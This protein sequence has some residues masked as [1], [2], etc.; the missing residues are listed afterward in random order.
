MFGVLR[1]P[2]IAACNDEI[3]YRNAAAS[4]TVALS[5]LPLPSIVPAFVTDNAEGSFLAELDIVDTRYMVSGTVLEDGVTVFVFRDDTNAEAAQASSVIASSTLAIRDPL[6]IL[7]HASE[8]VLPQLEKTGDPKTIEYVAMMHRGIFGI[9]RALNRLDAF[10]YLQGEQPQLDRARQSH[11]DLVRVCR[12]IAQTV[13]QV[14]DLDKDRIEF[15]SKLRTRMVFGERMLVERM[16]LCM[17]GN[18][19]IFT[20]EEASITVTVRETSRNAIIVVSDNGNGISDAAR[21][22]VW[23]RYGQRRELDDAQR[24]SGFGLSV[25]QAIT[26]MHGGGTM[27]ETKP[28]GGTSVIASLRLSEDQAEALVREDELK[29]ATA[30]GM[31]EIFTELAELIP[32]RKL[33]AKYLD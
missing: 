8:F 14:L 29:Y 22:D 33:S 1:E 18:A 12:E 16:V 4:Q 17:L 11:F 23:A 25:V 24:G 5:T 7:K 30:Q 31:T 27:I 13:T 21:Q 19:L 20:P 15:S 6:S 2:V 10:V 28:G 3:I 26:K 32:P 9:M